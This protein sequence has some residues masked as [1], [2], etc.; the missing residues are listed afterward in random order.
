MID[1]STCNVTPYTCP[2]RSL[3]Y[4]MECTSKWILRRYGEEMSQICVTIM[5]LGIPCLMSLL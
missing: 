3:C 2:F 5:S 1:G 4:T